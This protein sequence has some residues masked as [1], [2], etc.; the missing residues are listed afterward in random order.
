MGIITAIIVFFL[1]FI[2]SS[3]LFYSSIN[4]KVIF[5]TTIIS[6]FLMF[7]GYRKKEVLVNKRPLLIT[8]LVFLMA[9]YVSTFLGIYPE[10][11]LYGDILRST[12][13]YFITFLAL[14]AFA[15]SESLKEKD[16]Y[17]VKRSI[18]YSGSVFALLSFFGPAGLSVIEKSGLTLGN[19]TFAGAFL[20]LTF[21]I[22][23]IELTKA[24]GSW[25][26]KL[27]F[28]AAIQLLSPY[29]FG[30]SDIIGEARASSVTAWFVLIFFIGWWFIKK[31]RKA[32]WAWSIIWIIFIS[33]GIALLFTPGSFVQEVYVREA[34]EARIIVWANGIEAIKEKPLFGWGP[35]NINFALQKHFDN[36]LYLKK[37][38]GE[39]WFDR[40]HNFF[41]DTLIAVGVVGL[42]S[43]FLVIGA[44]FRV[45]YKSNRIEGG[46]KV[47]LSVIP[48]AH[49]L[50]LQTSFDTVITYTTLAIICSYVLWL[51]R[52]E[53][54]GG[55]NMA[56]PLAVLFILI[57][58]FGLFTF[59]YKEY[60]RQRALH[61][62]FFK[63]STNEEQVKEIEVATSRISNFESLRLG[64][65]SLINGLLDQI[66]RE[67]GS[68]PGTIS[69]GLVQLSVYEGRFREY[70][71]ESDDYRVRMNLAYILLIKTALG[72]SHVEGA[73]SIVESS[74]DMSPGN[75]LT[76]A[77]HSMALLFSGQVD[78]AK[79]KAQE[80]LDL[81]EDIELSQ[82]LVAY[83]DEQISNL[84][85]VTILRLQN[86]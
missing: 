10:R 8:F 38:I 27:G 43:I 18:V 49:I 2:Y 33:S 81:N 69:N 54:E 5:I 70:L 20:V 25:R 12:G 75:P 11:S 15:L 28:L 59:T 73:L 65:S 51:E 85:R 64:S 61:N 60:G 71:Q 31:Y 3:S 19:S 42:L 22:T 86:L 82:E 53:Y 76:Y 24:R 37:N 16:W 14:G 17:L 58:I 50:Q 1:P 52:Q 6:I 77:V 56:K 83:I 84:P 40:A 55:K 9:L 68:N 21:I 23:L 44:Y 35:E 7:F 30:Y 45:L 34:T 66:V 62:V 74:Y 80:T 4:P 72:E 63:A 48:F 79:E 39:V 32:V 67:G 46:E 57:G 78:S 36:E 29:L 41:I 26:W 47:L 13:V